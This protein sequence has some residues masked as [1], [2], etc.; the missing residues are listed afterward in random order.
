MEMWYMRD[1]GLVWISSVCQSAHEAFTRTGTWNFKTIQT[2][3]SMEQN[4]GF[5]IT[6]CCG[7]VAFSKNEEY[8]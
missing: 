2:Q 1:R 7:R 3:Q 5:K 4:E 8:K 6:K